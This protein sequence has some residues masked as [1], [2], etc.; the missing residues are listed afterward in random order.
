M[1]RQRCLKCKNN[2]KIPRFLLLDMIISLIINRKLYNENT[3]PR[4][5]EKNFGATELLEIR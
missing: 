5:L 2:G 3:A 4:S 1:K